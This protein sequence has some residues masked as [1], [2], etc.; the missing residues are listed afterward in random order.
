MC[1]ACLA[2]WKAT[3]EEKFLNRAEQLAQKFALEL[4]DL[5]QGLV[6]EHYSKNWLPD[7]EYHKDQPD[8]LFKPWGYQPGHQVEW[9]RLLMNLA[10]IRPQSWYLDRA[11]LLYRNG[12]RHGRDAD[13]GGVYYGFAP[14]GQTCAATKYFWVQAETIATA[15]RLFQLTKKKNYH[16]DYLEIWRYAWDHFVDHEHGAWFRILTRE[17]QKIDR[18]KSPPGKTDYHVL[19]VCWDILD[20]LPGKTR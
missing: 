13:H 1:E 6:W 18:F 20:H 16:Q 12:M 4:A 19:T 17:G 7:I 10:E 2:A 15:W 3:S 8:D 9:A 11:E 5:N 14:D